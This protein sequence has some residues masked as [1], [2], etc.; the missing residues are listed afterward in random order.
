[1]IYSTMV[2]HAMQLAYRAHNGQEDKEKYPYIHH[3]LHVAEQM[4]DEDSTVVA[5]LH[6]V[7]ED[8]GYTTERL[9]VIGYPSDIIQAV[10]LL[11]RKEG[12]SYKAYIKGIKTNSLATK[13]KLADLEH[14]MDLSRLPI[15]SDEDLQRAKKYRKAREYL[16]D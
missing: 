12:Q 8:C 15:V 1:M 9:R 2:C 11:S 4:D 13:V 7:F 6:D 14:N 5:L 16:L 3:V 10:D